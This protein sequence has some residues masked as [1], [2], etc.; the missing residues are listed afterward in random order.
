MKNYTCVRPCGHLD[1]ET[2]VFTRYTGGEVVSA[3][4]YNKLTRQLQGCFTRTLTD[5]QEAKLQRNL[6]NLLAACR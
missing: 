3:T 2:H 6:D 4:V 1:P 5:K